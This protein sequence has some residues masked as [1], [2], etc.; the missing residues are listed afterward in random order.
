M[1][2]DR[3]LNPVPAAKK[4]WDLIQLAE[5]FIEHRVKAAAVV[6]DA[7]SLVGVVGLDDIARHTHE[8][9]KSTSSTHAFYTDRIYLDEEELHAGIDV[10]EDERV[11][12][13][14]IMLPLI[15]QV[16]GQTT[17]G[18]VCKLFSEEQ[19]HRVIIHD[20]H[21]GYQGTVSILALLQHLATTTASNEYE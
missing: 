16:K 11:R 14:D 21:G 2:I 9:E 6:D 12:V 18:E 10:L 8:I 4:A 3:L 17:I 5:F 13:A 7:N 20:E 19:L 15:H 1:T